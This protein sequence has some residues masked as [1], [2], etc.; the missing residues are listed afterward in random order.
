[1]TSFE[2]LNSRRSDSSITYYI[3]KMKSLRTSCEIAKPIKFSWDCKIDAS[4][5]IHQ[6][7]DRTKKGSLMGILSTISRRFSGW[8]IFVSVPFRTIDAGAPIRQEYQIGSKSLTE[9]W[10]EPQMMIIGKSCWYISNILVTWSVEQCII[11]VWLIL[12]WS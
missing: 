3:V 11:D 9:T 5:P 8:W 4:A 12:P 2:C 10:W 7:V 6:I 1:M